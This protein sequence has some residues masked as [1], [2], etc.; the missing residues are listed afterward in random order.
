MMRAVDL[1]GQKFGR[2][3]VLRMLPQRRSKKRRGCVRAHAATGPLFPA[4]VCVVAA[5]D[6]AAACALNSL[7]RVRRPTACPPPLVPHLE[8]HEAA[9]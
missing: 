6:P 3:T 4:V 2:L 1:L 7:S 5:P 8:G 9:L